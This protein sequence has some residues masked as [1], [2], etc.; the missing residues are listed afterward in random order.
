M[1][2]NQA[3]TTIGMWRMTF[4]RVIF[5]LI[6]GVLATKLALLQ[7]VDVSFLQEKAAQRHVR[8]VEIPA[9]RGVIYDRHGEP[10]A[11]ST[12]VG[13][14]AVAPRKVNI[15]DP[16]MAM[17]AQL[18][19]RDLAEVQQRIRA[20][21]SR[22]LYLNR[23][24]TPA[25]E[26]QVRDL[27]MEGVSIEK[28]YKRYYPM[29]EVVAHLI[30]FTGV[31]D[32]GLEGLE[33]A[34]EDR[35]AGTK[36]ERRMIRDGN[37]TFVQ[38]GQVIK[39]AQP[40]EDLYLSIDLQ[41]QYLAYGALA[42]A[43]ETHGAKSGSI[44]VLDVKTG[45]VLAMA[46]APSFNPN[47]HGTTG[48]SRIR[49][50][51]MI[52]LFEPGST[53][54]PFT[55]AAGLN[56]G[57]YTTESEIN[58]SPGSF[59]VTSQFTVTDSRDYGIINLE[60][61]IQKS[62]NVGASKLALSLDPHELWDT[63]SSFGFARETGAK[64]PGQVFG[65]LP[66]QNTWHITERATMSYGYALSTT[67]LQLARAYMVFANGGLLTSIQLLK[68]KGNKPSI[69]PQRVFSEL[70]TT[71]VRDMMRQVT[72]PG[73]TGERGAVP[74]YSVAGKTG[75]ARRR[76]KGGGYQE[77][78]HVA[79]FAGIIPASDPKLVAV[80]VVDDPT[81]EG[82]HYGGLIA[83]PVFSEVMTGAMRLL[84]VAPDNIGGG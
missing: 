63:F 70:M 76:A 15:K 36:G 53:A 11:V 1:S 43:V 80:V 72:L 51:A 12:P 81:K 56:S 42:K 66:D 9:H 67:C 49:N 37:G 55:V 65:K 21:K 28:E 2:K 44:V 54:K 57:K 74:F 47:N 19:G 6:I 69:K 14:V 32:Q 29:G 18:L 31:E 48:F 4:L 64:F 24:I 71:Q 79:S 25:L 82:K 30:G 8:H 23:R 41:L 83:A 39:S 17:L 22:G 34:Y 3:N 27:G 7:M 73:G 33:L 78:H 77:G 58:T 5:V 26:K 75:T 68:Q 60:K 16:K 61:L 50:R 59:A 62:S 40:G 10:L 13:S 45:E 46:N 35:L 84:N 52:D 38:G 20:N